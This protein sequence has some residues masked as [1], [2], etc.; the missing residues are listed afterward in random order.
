MPT[1]EDYLFEVVKGLKARGHTVDDETLREMAKAV[2]RPEL[3]QMLQSGQ[4]TSQHIVD[5]ALQGVA[6]VRQR[7]QTPQGQLTGSRSLGPPTRTRVRG[8]TAEPAPMT[9]GDGRDALFRS[10][11]P[12]GNQA[13]GPLMTPGQVPPNAGGMKPLLPIFDSP[14]GVGGSQWWL[15]QNRNRVRGPI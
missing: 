12:I 1:L 3:L 13:F 9:M 5:E 15:R 2:Q 8:E 14:P 7:R 4:V 6:A 11:V 10:S